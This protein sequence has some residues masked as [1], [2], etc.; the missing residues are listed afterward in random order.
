MHGVET[1]GDFGLRTYLSDLKI[2]SQNWI[3]GKDYTGVVPDRF[4][5]ALGSLRLH[6]DQFV[7]IDFGSGK[8]RALLLASEFPFK[9]IIGIEFAP[10]LHAIAQ[11]N[12]QKYLSRPRQCMSI[13]SVCMDFIQFELP[14]APCVLYFLDPSGK[15]ILAKVLGN[16]RKSWQEHPRPLYIVYFSPSSEHLFDAADFL[17]KIDRNVEQSFSIYRT[18]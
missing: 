11:R 2:A 8:G 14:I 15:R 16:I 12:V 1:D 6:F 5:A 3:Y 9:K 18:R 4:F 13:E 7:F 17:L 10:E